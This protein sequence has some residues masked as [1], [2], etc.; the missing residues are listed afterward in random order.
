MKKRLRVILPLLAAAGAFLAWKKAHSAR[1]LYAGTVEATEVTLSSRLAS[2][3]KTV[4]VQEGAAV[5]AGQDL[6]ELGCEDIKL[7]ADM[8]RKDFDRAQRL[9]GQ[10]SVS[11]EEYDRLLSRRDAAALRQSW[12]RIQAPIAGRVLSRYHE[13]SEWVGPGTPL[14]T[15]ADL[16]S[17]YVHIYADQPELAKLSLGENV[18]AGLPEAPGRVFNG[19]VTHISD[20]AE[21]TP[22][23]V[24]TRKER[25][26]LVYAVK[27][28][29]ENPDGFLK[30]GMTL[31]VKLPAP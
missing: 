5:Q 15:L 20:E 3:I 10:G 14:L 16:S 12:C 28:S 18:D 13:P 19:T 4:Q 2:V 11:R 7:E 23:N 31:E 6:V 29:F 24:Q 25:V 30:P 27:V 22:K 21:F 26:R 8:A 1:F 9:L 17:V